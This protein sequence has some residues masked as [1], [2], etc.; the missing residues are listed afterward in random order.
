MHIGEEP[1]NPSFPINIEEVDVEAVSDFLVKEMSKLSLKEQYYIQQDVNGMNVLATTEPLQLSSMG[2]EALDKQ[3]GT[4]DDD[5]PCF[6]LAKRL[7]S[8]MIKEHCFRLKFA[9]ADRF[10]SM[11]AA[12]RME[13]YLKMIS[14]NFGDEI[15][16]RLIKL[17][18]LDKVCFMCSNYEHGVCNYCGVLEDAF[19]RI[20]L[21]FLVTKQI[22][23]TGPFEIWSHS[24]FALP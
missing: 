14:Q 11:K 22:G 6:R 9:R 19:I 1:V 15:L 8:K 18:D 16:K 20:G 10:D 12:N 5:Y 4:T 3:L 2:L 23:G 21:T 17:S 7:E 13:N 24:S